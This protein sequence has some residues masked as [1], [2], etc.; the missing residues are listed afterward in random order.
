MKNTNLKTTG[1][2]ALHI[3]SGTSITYAQQP[4]GKE[5]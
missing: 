2:S 5:G 4:Q 3:A 1:C